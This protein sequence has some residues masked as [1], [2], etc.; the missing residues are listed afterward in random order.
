MN[1]PRRTRR[2]AFFP[3]RQS[4]RDNSAFLT[5]RGLHPRWCKWNFPQ[6]NAGGVEH[7]IGHGC[8]DGRTR[9]FTSAVRGLIW[10]IN[11]SHFKRGSFR[12]PEQRI[13][14]PIGAGY[15]RAI[16]GDFFVQSPAECLDDVAFHLISET[17]GVD[18]ETAIVSAGYS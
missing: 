4:M 17:I 10:P 18:D 9:S 11:E 1:L 6:S 3:L 12:E 2:S 7:R 14:D 5:E 8:R 15:A 16:E 13:A